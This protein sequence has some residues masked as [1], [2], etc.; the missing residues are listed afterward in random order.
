MPLRERGP[1]PPGR[2]AGGSLRLIKCFWFWSKGCKCVGF[3]Q[4]L[5]LGGA[6]AF[7]VQ[8]VM[9]DMAITCVSAMGGVSTP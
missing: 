6:M 8:L 5:M 9:A 4:G 7:P 2:D 1:D 3:A